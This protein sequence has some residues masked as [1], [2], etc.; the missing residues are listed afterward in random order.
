[1]GALA[2]AVTGA[3]APLGFAVDGRP[4]RAHL[5]I[6]RPARPTDLRDAVALVDAAGPGPAW[7]AS[8]VVLFESGTRPDGVVHTVIAGVPLGL[9]GAAQGS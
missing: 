4:F 9:D 8:E 1:M 7:T 5:T 6:A 2:S 3:T